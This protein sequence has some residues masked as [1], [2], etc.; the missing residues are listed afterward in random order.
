MALSNLDKVFWPQEGYTKGDLLRYYWAV[1]DV[2]LPYLR[3]RPVV[4]T[5]Y[6]D[7]ILG[8]SFFQKDAPRHTP[9]WLRT[10]RLYSEHAQRGIDYFLCDNVDALL[11]LANLGTIPI[12]VWA[13]R[14]SQLQRPDWCILDLD[15]KGA[16]FAHVV[17]VARC[18]KRLCDEL[19]LPSYVKTSGQ[20]GLHV[21]W[22]TGGAVTFSQART[23]AEVL[24]KEVAARV[25]HLATLHRSVAARA[26]RVY[27]DY[28]QNGHG[29]LLVA[30]YAV[31]AVPG[32]LVSTPLA[33]REVSA[34]LDPR[35][36]TLRTVPRRVARLKGDPNLGLLSA[37][38]NLVM[39]LERL[40]LR[41][42]EAG[43]RP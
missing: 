13:S 12:H 26:G 8:K 29:K 37:Q 9:S 31:R 43:V 25:P 38:P 41:Q 39:A 17:L 42:R 3:E 14:I 23:F 15:P 5:R 27:L 34:T 19:E 22:P 28:L 11:Y 30:P 24:A 10:V 36:Y 18:L 1:A 16:P 33:W 40:L 35:R 21:L 2:M 20:S 7:G 4:L 32:A 6:P